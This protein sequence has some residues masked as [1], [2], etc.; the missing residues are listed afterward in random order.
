MFNYFSIKEKCY[1]NPEATVVGRF[2]FWAA[3]L[4]GITSADPT[5]AAS[6]EAQFKHPLIQGLAHFL[7]SRSQKHPEKLFQLAWLKKLV[8]FLVI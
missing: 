2:D 6:S 5:I 1:L 7:R 4:K 8:S 3:A